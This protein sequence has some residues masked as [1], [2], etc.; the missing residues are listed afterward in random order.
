MPF[1]EFSSH[2]QELKADFGEMQELQ[3]DFLELRRP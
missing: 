3:E 1:A 2:V